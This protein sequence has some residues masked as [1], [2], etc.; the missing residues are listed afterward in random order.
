M[1]F[2]IVGPQMDSDWKAPARGRNGYIMCP[3]MAPPEFLGHAGLE[4]SPLQGQR[5]LSF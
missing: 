3:G 5:I 2:E 4:A 1:L